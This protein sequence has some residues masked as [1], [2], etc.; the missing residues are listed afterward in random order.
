[1]NLINVGFQLKIIKI[2]DINDQL[3]NINYK[4][5]SQIII[6]T[7]PIGGNK[8]LIGIIIYIWNL[9]LAKFLNFLA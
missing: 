1:M 8:H 6:T 7:F 5:Y 9:F 4:N 2:N 3:I